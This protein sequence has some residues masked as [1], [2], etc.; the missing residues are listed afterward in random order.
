[1]RMVKFHAMQLLPL[2]HDQMRTE[3][4]AGAAGLHALVPYFTQLIAE[5]VQR[6]LH[7]LP[8]LHLLLQVLPWPFPPLYRQAS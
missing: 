3:G 5:E 4:V 7:D 6:S 8:R 2:V 1:M